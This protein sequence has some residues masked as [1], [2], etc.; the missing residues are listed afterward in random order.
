MQV[1]LCKEKDVQYSRNMLKYAVLQKECGKISIEID[2]LTPCLKRVEDGMLID[3]Y[4]MEGLPTKKELL[5]W[6][7]DWSQEAK[8][9][10]TVMRLYARGDSRLQGLISTKIRKD[11]HAIE[12]NLVEAAPMNNPHN[13][14]FVRKEYEGIGGH[15]FAE[16]IRQSYIA[17]F[18]GFV[19]F[20]A[21]TDLIKY[22]EDTLEAK[23]ANFKERTMY[24]D[25]RSAKKIYVQ[26]FKK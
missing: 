17:G 24:I 23:V 2:I 20:V 11:I 16:A 26:Y 14:M 15:L 8:K 12:I 7:F 21:K 22:Y 6:E 19:M 3:T 1:K 4:F 18:D 25:E 10:Y 13:K 9:G 5:N